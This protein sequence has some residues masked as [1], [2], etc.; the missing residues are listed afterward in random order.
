MGKTLNIFVVEDEKLMS[1]MLCDHLEKNPS[2]M[3]TLFQTGED[4]L[5]KLHLKPDVIILDLTLNSVVSEA[6]DGLKILGQIKNIDENIYVVMLSSQ[7]DRERIIQ[8]K[9]KGAIDYV[10]KNSGAFEKI[11]HILDLVLSLK[12]TVENEAF[13]F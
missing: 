10:V 11:D 5:P 9:V 6:R 12:G 4:C 7:A 13:R 2:H 1:T 8:T 3:V